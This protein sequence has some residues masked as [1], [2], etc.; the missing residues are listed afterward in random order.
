M[1]SSVEI[2]QLLLDTPPPK[3]SD[4]FVRVRQA[5]SIAAVD[6]RTIQR[7]IEN[8]ELEVARL[9]GR[10]WILRTSLYA[11]IKRHNRA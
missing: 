9:G 5:A 2:T 6:R 1:R 10:V 8:G 11:R 3:R 4:R 7:W